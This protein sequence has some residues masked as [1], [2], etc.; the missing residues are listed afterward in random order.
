MLTSG[1]Q[2][3]MIPGVLLMQALHAVNLGT[4]RQRKPM[5]ELIL[6][7][8][9]EKF[10]WIICTAVELRNLFSGVHTMDCMSTTVGIV[11]MQ[12]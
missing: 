1:T 3:V 8:D 10:S 9:Q 12:V 5:R 2:C 6:A 4:E 7:K 11:K